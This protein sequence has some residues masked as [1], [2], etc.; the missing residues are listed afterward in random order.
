[1]GL[2]KGSCH[3]PK[4]RGV[5]LA[6]ERREDRGYFWCRNCLSWHFLPCPGDCQDG[7][8]SLERD[9]VD[10][11]IAERAR[12]RSRENWSGDDHQSHD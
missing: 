10:A 11:A 4:C 5:H 2:A 8:T 3:E 1:M 9:R 7:L 12:R 6:A